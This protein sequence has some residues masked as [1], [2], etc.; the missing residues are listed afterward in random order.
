MTCQE[1]RELF[2]AR[3]DD[4]LSSEE[5]ATIDAHLATCAECAREWDR[6]AHTV[7]LLRAVVPARAPI[8]FVDRVLAARPRPWYRRLARRVFLPWPVKVPLEAAAVVMVAGLA[9]LIFQRSPE[10][11][12]A[13]RGPEPT[14]VVPAPPAP[15]TTPTAPSTPAT[16]P[17]AVMPPAPTAAPAPAT[18]ERP[19]ELRLPDE[20]KADDARQAPAEVRKEAVAPARDAAP[21]PEPPRAVAE[22]RA[23]SVEPPAAGSLRQNAEK[24]AGGRAA[25]R[26]A[27]PAAAKT[28]EVQKL[29][30]VRSDALARLA[31][32][33]R[34]A[35]ERTVRSLVARAGGQV[36]THAQ[37]AEATVFT[38]I[39]PGERWDELQRELRGLGPLYLE[40]SRDTTVGVLRVTLRLER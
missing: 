12:Q 39:V 20:K 31:V 33:D 23:K 16:P 34:D 36:V 2:S 8:G 38:L 24:D 14:V 7:G 11:Q 10:L 22:S 28:P 6:F 26:G 5:R 32:T 37:E 35:A 1:I 19:L 27:A 30:A 13:A 15:A 29:A 3:V 40:R 9:V 4:A 18:P 25:P 17:E 21:E